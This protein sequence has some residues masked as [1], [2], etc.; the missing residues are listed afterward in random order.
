MQQFINTETNMR[1]K[2][3]VLN[4]LKKEVKGITLIVL[5][6][7][8]IVLLILAGV[9]INLTIGNNGIFKR[10][11]QATQEYTKS[12][13]KEK[14]ILAL[15]GLSIDKVSGSNSEDISGEKLKNQLVNDGVSKENISV[16]DSSD[17]TIYVK[18][19]D[20]GNQYEVDKNGNIKNS[21]QLLKDNVKIGD[22]ID[23]NPGE[24]HIE[25]LEE[26]N[27]YKDYVFN[28][29]NDTKWRVW[30][31]TEDGKVRIIS[32][33]ILY[34]NG[35]TGEKLC[36][37]GKSGWENATDELEKICSIY[38]HGDGAESATS[39]SEE[40]IKKIVEWT[41]PDSSTGKYYGNTFTY[42]ANHST[43]T[44][45]S[46]IGN[47]TT[48]QLIDGRIP[49]DENPIVIENH[50]WRP[51]ITNDNLTVDE[52]KKEL[53]KEL[54]KGNYTEDY[55]WEKLYWIAGNQPYYGS[56]N[57]IIY[58][59]YLMISRLEVGSATVTRT[60]KNDGDF[61]ESSIRPIITLDNG[62]NYVSG[63]GKENDKIKFD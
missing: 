9:A 10:A 62:L 43:N 40:D 6:V 26:D 50:M 60:D 28:S 24:E 63:S 23:Y 2:N 41:E 15:Q 1:N 22:Y 55:Q 61:Y 5:V 29:S 42:Y 25:S 46:T 58:N 45:D 27:G 3:M 32:E 7:T 19:L 56:N 11:G 53:V 39:I 12:S 4:K 37:N 33:D 54:L 14:I 44:Y 8:I 13:E 38:G 52:N 57:M 31:I 16:R 59:V 17:N 36:F 49:T 47:Y 48:F 18:F 51:L 30:D 35:L 34:T 20:T 21:S